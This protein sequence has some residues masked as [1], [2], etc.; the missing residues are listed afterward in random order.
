[1]LTLTI[2]WNA[3]LARLLQYL[4]PPSSILAKSPCCIDW[5]SFGCIQ[6][7]ITKCTGSML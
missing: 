3:Q 2:Y 7:S 4:A 6:V 5:P 1:M